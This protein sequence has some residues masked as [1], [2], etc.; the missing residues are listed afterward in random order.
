MR[1]LV[2][3]L[4]IAFLLAAASTDAATVTSVTVTYAS[5]G[6]DL[7][8]CNQAW[9][10]RTN[11]E[12]GCNKF[13]FNGVQFN[14]V[15]NN[16][17]PG[18]PNGYYAT[19]TIPLANVNTCGPNLIAVL[20]T[21][22][23][24]TGSSIGAMMMS[25]MVTINF[26]DGTVMHVYSNPENTKLLMLGPGAG[27][28]PPNTLQPVPPL[29][30]TM[31]Y[32]DSAWPQACRMPTSIENGG[33][34]LGIYTRV[35]VA[36]NPPYGYIPHLA[37]WCNPGFAANQATHNAYYEQ[38]NLFRNTFSIPCTTTTPTFTA[39][40]T[41]TRTITQTSTSTST[42]SATPTPT[43]TRTVTPTSTSSSTLTVTRTFTSTVTVSSSS[44]A[45][46]SRTVTPTVTPSYSATITLTSTSTATS[47]LSS[48]PSSTFTATRTSTVTGT[49]TSSVTPSRTSTP[50]STATAT[51][52]V[53]PSSTL[54]MT[55]T[56]SRTV[57]PSVT[58]TFLDTFTDTSTITRTDTATSSPTQTLTGTPSRTQTTT[59]TSTAS[60]T[61][62]ATLTA[63]PSSSATPTLTRTATPTSSI[64][65]T[66]TSTSSQTPGPSATN[67]ATPTFSGT[68]TPTRTS[69]ETPT[70]SPTPSFTATAT[71]TRT[72]TLSSTE[73]PSH[74]PTASSTSTESPGPSATD[75]ATP[76]STSTESPT[77]TV[78]PTFTVTQSQTSTPSGTVTATATPTY[79]VT[80]SS[81][82]SSTA[83]PSF[84]ATLPNTFTNTPTV[85]VT[86]TFTLTATATPSRTVSPTG[87]PSF[88]SSFTFTETPTVTPSPTITQSFT[89]SPTPIPLPYPIRIQLYNAAGELVRTLYEGDGQF[90]PSSVGLSS[91]TLA[92]GSGTMSFTFH[93]AL[94]GIGNGPDSSVVW[95]GSND[96][97]Q[98]VKSGQY[99]AKI[100]SSDAFGNVSSFTESVT[101]IGATLSQKL[102]VFN[103]AGELVS[104]VQ[105]SGSSMATRFEVTETS[106]VL[107]LD[108]S[109]GLPTSGFNIL[110]VD[111]AGTQVWTQW[112][113][114]NTQ[115]IPVSP[116]LYTMELCTERPGGGVDRVSTSV[117]VLAAPMSITL[118]DPYMAP[119][120]Y[121]NGPLRVFYRS[122]PGNETV[123][124][125]LY[126][127]AG[128]LVLEGRGKGQNGRLELDQA[129]KLASGV[130][131]LDLCWERGSG[132]VERKRAK[133]AVAH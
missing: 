59:S 62:S 96:S 60:A 74:T 16:Y 50:S 127:L 76:T 40:Q 73:T 133:V 21:D 5:D 114:L 124:A 64:T 125:R 48:T 90:V 14:T 129:E 55:P 43:L 47:T 49:E 120:P 8:W 52:S 32:N 86:P 83:T 36:D 29:W 30:N 118:G 39:T 58:V 12:Q 68:A 6:G 91:P 11:G 15:A 123:H 95:D 45:T 98:M 111:Q 34:P 97:G 22:G 31:G 81:T 119:Q 88:T 77:R 122:L 41:S 70:D 33:L 71:A 84:T 128:E 131:L 26:S 69:T 27:S 85:S 57:T 107:E 23:P 1:Q 104:Q 94:R 115:G 108:P 2:L 56:Y 9:A 24:D 19:A 117:Q 53:T 130:Y 105:L 82:P 35:N 51:S 103:G 66:S 106:K 92:A 44:T 4:M 80:R 38:M 20:S 116:G 61:P 46:P 54:T 72:V 7:A 126:N 101:V 13:Y 113:G 99:Y 112:S 18:A 67:S 10:I 28:G 110:L 78:T 132:V 87:T 3:P 89:F 79:S 63:T 17:G 100:E 93:G 42:L 102:S 75:T 109:T 37:H 65:Q 121:K 25:F